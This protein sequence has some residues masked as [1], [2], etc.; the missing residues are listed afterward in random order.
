MA[1]KL[2]KG[3]EKKSF[4][5]RAGCLFGSKYERQNES[6]KV[7]YTRV[8]KL[9]EGVL[10]LIDQVSPM[11]SWGTTPRIRPDQRGRSCFSAL[12][13]SHFGALVSALGTARLIC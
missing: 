10:D 4:E 8:S 13:K 7:L 3:K 9:G 11:Q 1:P 5:T 6:A 2:Q 12:L